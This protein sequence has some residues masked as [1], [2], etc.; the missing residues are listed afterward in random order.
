MK[1]RT[2][3]A[4]KA[5]SVASLVFNMGMCLGGFFAPPLGV[6]DN[7]VLIALGIIGLQGTIPTLVGA[8][9]DVK[10]KHNDTEVTISDDGD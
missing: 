7:S 8:T 2:V 6:I 4:S 3:S 5:W 10:I 9:K 1:K